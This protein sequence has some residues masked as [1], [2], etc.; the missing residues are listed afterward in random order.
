MPWRI[1]PY[2]SFEGITIQNL[3]KFNFDAGGFHGKNYGIMIQ[4]GPYK[5]E[6]NCR[7]QKPTKPK[8]KTILTTKD[9]FLECYS[10]KTGPHREYVEPDNKEAQ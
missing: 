8:R 2:M 5:F 7:R 3:P 6:A 1:L 4:L 10:S 9:W